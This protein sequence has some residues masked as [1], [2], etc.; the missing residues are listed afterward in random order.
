MVAGLRK[1]IASLRQRLRAEVAGGPAAELTYDATP[2]AATASAYIPSPGTLLA[3]AGMP[4]ASDAEEEEGIAAEGEDAEAA[5]AGPS[6]LSPNGFEEP[7]GY[8]GGPNLG[9]PMSVLNSSALATAAARTLSPAE[10]LGVSQGAASRVRKALRMV[11]QRLGSEA[12]SGVAFFSEEELATSG[13]SSN[14]TAVNGAANGRANGYANGYTNGYARPAAA[15]AAA[16]PALEAVA[17]RV[18]EKL[19]G[20][21]LLTAAEQL[22]LE[23]LYIENARLK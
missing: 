11:E 21:E 14:G 17:E 9:V 22:Q 6:G 3:G 12:A 8:N 18:R 13:G 23:V 1:E 7:N 10:G 16:V 2:A 4:Q 15:A 5:A 20:E 19:Q